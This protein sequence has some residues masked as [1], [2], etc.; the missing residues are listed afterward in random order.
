MGPEPT[1]NGVVVDLEG[2]G[3]CTILLL[4][5]RSPGNTRGH[6]IHYWRQFAINM[7]I[8][9]PLGFAEIDLVRLVQVHIDPSHCKLDSSYPPTPLIIYIE[10]DKRLILRLV[11]GVAG[12][13]TVSTLMPGAYILY[14]TS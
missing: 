2:R 4:C 8:I 10:L 12:Q 9:S 11:S 6:I 13:L 5:V 1:C 3:G 14:S 7:H